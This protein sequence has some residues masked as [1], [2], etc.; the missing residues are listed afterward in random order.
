[1]MNSEIASPA[2]ELWQA[3]NDGQFSHFSPWLALYSKLL[4][5]V[6]FLLIIAGGLVTSTQSG[7]SVPDWPLSYGKWMPPMVGGIRYEHTH[8]MIASLVGLMT[9]VLTVWLGFSER[10]RW[11]RWLGIAAFGAVVVQGIL[12]GFTVLYLL[13]APVSI[14]HACLA[15]TFFALVTSLAFVTSKEWTSNGTRYGRDRFCFDCANENLSRSVPG[16]V[17]CPL[18]A[19]L[20]MMVALVYLQLI[21][22][23]TLRHTTNSMVAISH[24]VSAFLVLIHAIIV[25][26]RAWSCSEGDNG[27]TRPAL[28]IGILTLLQM[29]LGMGAFIYQFMLGATAQ[30]SEGKIFFVTAHQSLGALL[31]ATSVLFALKVFRRE[32]LV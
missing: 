31:L 23:A 13:P 27:I 16:T 25:M 12:G 21:L 4:V 3:R 1:M 8:R 19:P 24:V 10:R 29:A 22:G 18:L 14:F 6:T 9:L 5:F 15:Q 20:W 30:S 7:L 11:V 32:Q 28:A 26:V 17:E 2:I